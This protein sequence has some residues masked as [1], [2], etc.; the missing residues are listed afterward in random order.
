M[1]IL[2]RAYKQVLRNYR[3]ISGLGQAS[4]TLLSFAPASVGGYV[5]VMDSNN[6]PVTL[7][8]GW[9][10]IERS[11]DET[12]V[13]VLEIVL[14]EQDGVSFSTDLSGAT[15]SEAIINAAQL[16]A[17]FNPGLQTQSPA[18]TGRVIKMVGNL[19]DAPIGNPRNYARP[20]QYSGES[21][22]LPS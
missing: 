17:L 12:T 18:S 21:W 6:Q 19:L 7:I 1:D 16:I 9:A 5:A 2:S 20:I 8:H 22:T 15:V 3:R 11:D 4:I 14:D 13:P 10:I